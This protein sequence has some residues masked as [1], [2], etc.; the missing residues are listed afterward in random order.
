[1]WGTGFGSGGLSDKLTTQGYACDGNTT[2][3]A[4]S[5]DTWIFAGWSWNGSLGI[6]YI[7]G[8][9]DMRF[10]KKYANTWK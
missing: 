2:S 1:M 5:V 10:T 8:V 4:Q 3:T 7:D 6:I 9:E